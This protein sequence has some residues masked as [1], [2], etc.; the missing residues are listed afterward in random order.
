M[1]DSRDL[2]KVAPAVAESMANHSKT[3]KDRQIA[4]RTARRAIGAKAVKAS[5]VAGKAAVTAPDRPRLTRSTS[6]KADPSEITAFLKR[7]GLTNRQAAEA[8]GVSQ[9]LLSTVQRQTGDRWS[10]ERWKAAQ[11][12]LIA[13]AKKVAAKAK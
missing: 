5:A 8:L 1:A 7:V 10:F 2:A 11:P 3:V 13:A 6:V 12:I 4:E 9:S